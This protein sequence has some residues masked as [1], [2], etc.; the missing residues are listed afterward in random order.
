MQLWQWVWGWWTPL[1]IYIAVRPIHRLDLKQK[2]RYWYNF[3]KKFNNPEK[4]KCGPNQHC[5]ARDKDHECLCNPGYEKTLSY[6]TLGCSNID[7]CLSRTHT[8][9]ANSFCID[10]E[11]SFECECEPGFEGYP[12]VE[13]SKDHHNGCCTIICTLSWTIYRGAYNLQYTTYVEIQCLDIDECKARTSGCSLNADCH[14]NKGGWECECFV[15]FRGDGTNCFD[16]DECI[17]NIDECGDHSTCLN[18][19]GLDLTRLSLTFG[20]IRLY[21]VQWKSL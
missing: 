19:V 8:C 3:L 15:G 14:N 20:S 12:E 10:T 5:V 18:T 16:I 6:E 13:V 11:G 17:E 9:V 1:W 7:E 4:V 21:S 2:L